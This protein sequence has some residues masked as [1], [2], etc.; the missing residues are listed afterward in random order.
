MILQSRVGVPF[1]LFLKRKGLPWVPSSGSWEP[2]LYLLD[3]LDVPGPERG[4]P[5]PLRAL[6]IQLAFRF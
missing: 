6:A 4:G 3:S 5:A 1:M 2:I